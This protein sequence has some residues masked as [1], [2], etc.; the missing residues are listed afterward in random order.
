MKRIIGHRDKKEEVVFLEIFYQ[1]YSDRLLNYAFGFLKSKEETEEAVQDI[2]V[3]F[4]SKRHTIESSDAYEAYLFVMAKR[5]L[6]NLLRKKARES[7]VTFEIHKHTKEERSV[8]HQYIYEEQLKY[9]EKIIEEFPPKR[10]LVYE[11]K[12]NQGLTNKQIADKMQISTTMVEKHWRIA[13]STLKDHLG[14]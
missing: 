12:K 4:W 11:L 9:V 10:K 8:E 2:F 6:L 1:K 14:K 13:V 5:H 3:K 7:F